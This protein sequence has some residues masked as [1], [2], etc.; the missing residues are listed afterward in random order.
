VVCATSLPTALTPFVGRS[1]QIAQLVQHVQRHRLLTLTGAG[2]MGKT[3]LA[4]AVAAQVVD[5]F[6]D[7]VWFVDLAPL[8]D[9]NAMPQCI[10][11]LW[12]VPEQAAR[13]SLE[14]LTAYLGAKQI[15]LILDNCEHLINACAALAETLLQHCP[16]LSLLATNREALNIGGELP[17]RA[18]SLTRL[19]NASQRWEDAA[20]PAQRHLAPEALLQFE[21]VALFV[22]RAQAR[23]PGCRHPA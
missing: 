19:S 6:A 13:S 23:S 18:P 3:R 10:L 5:R 4:L 8:T 12:R 15:L 16:E 17:W 1:E 9:P 20:A 14:T 21:A 7:G 11:D 22:E 2:G